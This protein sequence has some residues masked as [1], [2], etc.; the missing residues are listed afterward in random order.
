MLAKFVLDSIASSDLDGMSAKFEEV[1]KVK[2]FQ[3]SNYDGKNDEHQPPQEFMA[4]NNPEANQLI[5]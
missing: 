3:N 5:L 2:K 1:L 4:A